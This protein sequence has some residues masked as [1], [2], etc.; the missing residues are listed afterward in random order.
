VRIS[1]AALRTGIASVT[2]GATPAAEPRVL[3]P[4]TL[5]VAILDAGRP[6]RAFRRIN[7]AEL[8]SLLAGAESEAVADGPSA[9]VPE[10]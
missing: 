3:G 10:T 4:S 1:V 2:G 8:E 6:R 9:G 5:E 7:G